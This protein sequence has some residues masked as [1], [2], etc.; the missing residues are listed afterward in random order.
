MSNRDGK[1]QPGSLQKLPIA[2]QMTLVSDQANPVGVKF[3]HTDDTRGYVYWT[4]P[5]ERFIYRVSFD[6][7]NLETIVSDVRSDSLAI[8]WIS[9]NLYWRT[10]QTCQFHSI[11][12]KT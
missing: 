12:V 6:D 11:I 10:I 5:A 8:D 1:Y 9:G 4:D 7:S 3:Y 2:Y